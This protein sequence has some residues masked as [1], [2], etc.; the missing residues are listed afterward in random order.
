MK[1]IF[2]HRVASGNERLRPCAPDGI[3]AERDRGLEVEQTG[4]VDRVRA[5][6]PAAKVRQ[7]GSS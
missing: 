2:L 3:A 1:R 5:D 7:M 6:P 4:F